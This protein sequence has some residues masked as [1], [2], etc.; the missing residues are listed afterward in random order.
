MNFIILYYIFAMTLAQAKVVDVVTLTKNATILVLRPWFSTAGPSP[1]HVPQHNKLDGIK[2][3]KIYAKLQEVGFRRKL[4]IQVSRSKLC[5]L[6]QSKK[7]RT[8]VFDCVAS[9][10][11]KSN[12]FCNQC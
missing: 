11:K 5:F 2:A 7:L 10:R 8:F 9:F 12:I 4:R 1:S 6:S 3:M